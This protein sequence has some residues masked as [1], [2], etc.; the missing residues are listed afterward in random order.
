MDDTI[1]HLPW[2]VFKINSCEVQVWCDDFSAYELCLANYNQLSY[3]GNKDRY[4]IFR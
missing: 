2:S 3:G 1:W 4:M